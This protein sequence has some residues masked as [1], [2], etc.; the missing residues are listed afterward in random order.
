MT[1][2]GG[3]LFRVDVYFGKYG[4]GDRFVGYKCSFR[5]SLSAVDGC[6]IPTPIEN[7]EATT[8]E[9]VSAL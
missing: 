2:F 4:S 1:V 3:R 7:G 9:L 5:F 8:T 6:G